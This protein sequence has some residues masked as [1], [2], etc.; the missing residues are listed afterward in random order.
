MDVIVTQS[1][2]GYFYQGRDNSGDEQK[3]KSIAFYS[4]ITGQQTLPNI[5]KIQL[6]VSEIGTELFPWRMD[7]MSSYAVLLSLQRSVKGPQN[8][9]R[10]HAVRKNLEFE[11]RRNLAQLHRQAPQQN[12]LPDEAKHFKFGQTTL[13]EIVPETIQKPGT[14]SERTSLVL[15]FIDGDGVVHIY[16]LRKACLQMPPQLEQTLTSNLCAEFSPDQPTEPASKGRK[17]KKDQTEDQAEEKK[18]GSKQEVL[19]F[20]DETNRLYI[21]KS[22]FSGNFLKCLGGTA[23]ND[24]PIQVESTHLALLEAFKE[25]DYRFLIESKQLD[26]MGIARSTLWCG[27]PEM[28]RKFAHTLAHIMSKGQVPQSCKLYEILTQLGIDASL[29]Q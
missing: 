29:L 18:P 9:N 25:D 3:P 7:D 2:G 13:G 20:Q 11:S 14:L 1:G 4:E 22:R 19:C 21:P 28:Q 27:E 10:G 6:P 23:E 15:F 12:K 24:G 17:R 8:P 26:L 5:S 16:F